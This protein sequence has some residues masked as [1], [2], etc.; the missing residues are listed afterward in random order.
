[1]AQQEPLFAFATEDDVEDVPESIY[2]GLVEV[3]EELQELPKEQLERYR[4]VWES[5]GH[6][7]STSYSIRG[8][9]A[10]FGETTIEIIGGRGGEYY[11]F[12]KKGDAP[13]IKYEDPDVSRDGWGEPLEHLI[14]LKPDTVYEPEDGWGKWFRE[15]Y[16][17][18]EKL[19]SQ[20]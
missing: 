18:V 2:D 20:D 17:I 7:H 13:W 3:T 10:Q 5:T 1:M 4:V 6:N 19:P 8:L 15:A 16:T 9:G 14:I 12:P 11:I